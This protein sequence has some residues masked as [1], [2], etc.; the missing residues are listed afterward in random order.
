MH[1]GEQL[2]HFFQFS[3][4]KHCAKFQEK[5]KWFL[6]ENCN[7]QT[8]GSYDF[9]FKVESIEKRMVPT[10]ILVSSFFLI[11]TINYI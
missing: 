4:L 1:N 7:K 11:F 8:E 3:A 2:L 6:R 5:N 9:L 10:S